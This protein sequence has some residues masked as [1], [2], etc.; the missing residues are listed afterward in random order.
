M[1]SN[2]PEVRDTEGLRN[3]DSTLDS[4]C[5]FTLTAL[6]ITSKCSK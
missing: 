1:E 5:D 6:E 4:L 3:W 2:Y